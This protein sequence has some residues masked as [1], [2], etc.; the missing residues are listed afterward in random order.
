[1]DLDEA[2]KMVSQ[3]PERDPYRFYP[4]DEHPLPEMLIEREGVGTLP[5]KDITVIAGKAKNGKSF[6]VSI[7]I[8]SVLGETDFFAPIRQNPKVLYFDT[9]QSDS[10]V[11]IV[12]YRICKLLG[13]ENP[14]VFRDDL[15]F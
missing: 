4:E 3:P 7:F 15:Q 11:S 14:K 9:E 8:A 1:M 2:L 10:N 5:L 6:V 12:Y 13:M